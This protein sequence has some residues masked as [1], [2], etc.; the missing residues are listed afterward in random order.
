LLFRS[1]HVTLT[2]VRLALRLSAA[3]MRRGFFTRN[4]T[5]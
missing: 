4:K 3:F 1:C 2:A 5:N